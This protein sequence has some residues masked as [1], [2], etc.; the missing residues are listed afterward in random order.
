M[1]SN[2]QNNHNRR[3]S[4]ANVSEVSF[5]FLLINAAFSTGSAH[6]G[7]SA[8]SNCCNF[9]RLFMLQV[10]FLNIRPNENLQSTFGHKKI[11]QWNI[12]SK[13]V[14]ILTTRVDPYS[15]EWVQQL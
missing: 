1:L 3:T 10:H 2:H 5:T 14:I 9:S 15:H 6:A 4:T 13:C 7:I 12:V 8:A 11:A